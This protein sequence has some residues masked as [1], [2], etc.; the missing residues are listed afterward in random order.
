MLD[1]I[2]IAYG[3]TVTNATKHTPVNSNSK[4]IIFTPK[5]SI[6]NPHRSFVKIFRL[7]MNSQ[8]V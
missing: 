6:M 1:K 4:N 8:L 5:G 3:N 2:F 7:H